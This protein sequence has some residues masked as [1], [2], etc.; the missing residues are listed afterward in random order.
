MTRSR[1]ELRGAKRNAR[2]VDRYL[3]ALHDGG[4]D[5]KADFADLEQ[6]FAVVARSFSLRNGISYDAWRDVGVPSALLARAGV[7]EDRGLR[8]LSRRSSRCSDT[9]ALEC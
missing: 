1:S 9:A 2:L 4:A 6:H 5:A 3:R 8:C 7:G